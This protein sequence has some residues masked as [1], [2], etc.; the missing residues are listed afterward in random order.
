MLGQSNLEYCCGYFEIVIIP[1]VI[2]IDTRFKKLMPMS[3]PLLI[4]IATPTLR[5]LIPDTSSSGTTTFFVAM[6]PL[7]VNGAK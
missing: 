7:M 6:T 3:I 2:V 1:G 5:S 4:P